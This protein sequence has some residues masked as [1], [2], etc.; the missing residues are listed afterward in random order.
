MMT[1]QCRGP[2]PHHLAQLCRKLQRCGV[3]QAGYL[4][5]RL[6]ALMIASPKFKLMQ[7]I[8]NTH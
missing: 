7:S 5:V 8:E 6:L 1:Q 2:F 4:Q 3:L